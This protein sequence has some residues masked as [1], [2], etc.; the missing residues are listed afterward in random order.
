MTRCPRCSAPL[1]GLVAGGSARG[2][3][4][5]CRCCSRFVVLMPDPADPL[6]AVAV[7]EAV[8]LARWTS[9]L[10]EAIESIP[11]PVATGRGPPAHVLAS[12][13]GAMSHV[14]Q[15]K[16]GPRMAATK[17]KAPRL[18]PRDLLLIVCPIH[19]DVH[20]SSVMVAPLALVVRSAATVAN[21]AVGP[22]LPG[23]YRV[24]T[25]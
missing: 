12:C 8:K 11:A 16:G 24:P 25:I 13:E 3:G 5:R 21:G 14:P 23:G 20:S 17:E 2:P 1:A 9:E 6:R 15:S 19:Y 10:F 7:T 18:S 4:V 22:N